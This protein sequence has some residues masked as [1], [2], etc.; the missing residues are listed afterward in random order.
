MSLAGGRRN[1]SHHPFVRWDMGRRRT[2]PMVLL[3]GVDI[4]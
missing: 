2:I 4:F 3:R 1:T